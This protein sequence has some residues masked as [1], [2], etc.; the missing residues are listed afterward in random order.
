MKESD[1]PHRCF[2]RACFVP[3]IAHLL[4]PELYTPVLP[5]LHVCNVC[6]TTSQGSAASWDRGLTKPAQCFVSHSYAPYKRQSRT[7]RTI[8]HSPVRG[9]ILD[10]DAQTKVYKNTLF[11]LFSYCCQCLSIKILFFI[12]PP[13]VFVCAR[14]DDS[15]S[16]CRMRPDR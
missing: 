15:Q 4:R 10:H 3:L 13:F 9:L 16:R 14:L 1:V 11:T 6:N 7:L 12:R 8:L 5:V 2:S